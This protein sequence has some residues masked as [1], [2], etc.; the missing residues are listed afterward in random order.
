MGCVVKSIEYR[1]RAGKQKERD[2]GALALQALLQ[3]A[4]PEEI[5]EQ[6]LQNI[7]SNPRTP[8]GSVGFFRA[9]GR[10]A[11]KCSPELRAALF[12]VLVTR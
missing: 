7:E 6:I 10:K 4:Q 9:V 12:T 2:A 1:D 5:A 11:R 8:R 3:A